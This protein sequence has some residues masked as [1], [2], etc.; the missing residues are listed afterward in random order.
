MWVSELEEARDEYYGYLPEVFQMVMDD[1]SASVIARYL[2]DIT[3]QRMGL[4]SNLKR[5]VPIR[6]ENYQAAYPAMIIWWRWA[7]K[8]PA[9]NRC[10]IPHRRIALV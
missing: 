8:D 7:S 1:A 5:H 6:R 2:D 4:K 3:T 10:L 9:S